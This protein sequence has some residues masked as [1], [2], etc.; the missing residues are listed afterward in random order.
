MYTGVFK[1]QTFELIK[2]GIPLSMK[3]RDLGLWT[4][5]CLL[6]AVRIFVLQ[7]G[8]G[9]AF[10]PFNVQIQSAAVHQSENSDRL[11]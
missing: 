11:R 4:R 5:T 1:S 3:D 7:A 2:T 6:F 10:L 8:I 9:A